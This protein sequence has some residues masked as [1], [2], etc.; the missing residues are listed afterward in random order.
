MCFLWCW[1]NM[2]KV[3]LTKGKVTMIIY[4]RWANGECV[5][6]GE[7][8]L[9]LCVSSVNKRSIPSCLFW[10]VKWIE[11]LRPTSRSRFGDNK[12]NYYV[13]FR[14]PVLKQTLTISHQVMLHIHPGFGM[15]TQS[16]LH[17]IFYWTIRK[18]KLT[19]TQKHLS[20]IKYICW[21][22]F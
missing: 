21:L 17:F 20:I 14:V 10:G 2:H 7:E 1:C 3:N 6:H 16:S 9:I 11:R 12:S 19:Q 5:E 4:K 13:K 18:I 22:F 8:Q 15:S